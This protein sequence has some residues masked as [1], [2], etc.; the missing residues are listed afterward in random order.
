MDHHCPW[1]GNCVGESNRKAFLLLLGYGTLSSFIAAIC[2]Y[3]ELKYI[4]NNK[5]S[6]NTTEN[7]K[8]TSQLIKASLYYSYPTFGFLFSV[9][10][11]TIMIVL[12]VDQMNWLIFNMTHI[13]WLQYRKHKYECPYFENNFIKHFY[14]VF[15]EK[16]YQWFIPNEN[17]DNSLYDR[18]TGIINDKF[19]ITD[20]EHSSLL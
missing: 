17:P 10:S 2:I 18:E 15:G 3:Y 6:I 7:M 11:F 20:E 16:W 4:I 9:G 8:T 13:E 12:I 14:I 5:E 1:I 19:F